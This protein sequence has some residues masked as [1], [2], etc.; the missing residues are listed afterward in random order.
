MTD[1]YPC[2]ICGRGTDQRTAPSGSIRL[3]R[4]AKPGRGE[5]PSCTGTGWE[6]VGA[7][8][9]GDPTQ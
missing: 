1:T 2:P 3:V 4:H 9:D 8:P 6:T 7:N 5:Q